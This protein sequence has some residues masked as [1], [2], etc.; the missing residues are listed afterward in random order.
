MNELIKISSFASLGDVP[1][2]SGRELHEAL[3]VK[4]RYTQWF[5]RMCEYGFV[6]GE[7]FFTILGKSTGGRPSTDHAL[8]I[9]T[10]KEICMIQRTEI[11]RTIRRYFIETEKKYKQQS[12]STPLYADTLLMLNQKQN[13]LESLVASL[14]GDYDARMEKLENDLKEKEV[15]ATEYF[16]TESGHCRLEIGFK[17][18]HKQKKAGR[19]WVGKDD[20]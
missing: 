10:A 14:K 2:V 13:E 15:I 9:D 11:G 17:V 6:E 7:D 19:R 1:T 18:P 8:T 3:E 12:P 20:D 16:E 5:T 4:D